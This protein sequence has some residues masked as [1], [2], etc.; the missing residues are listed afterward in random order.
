M[1]VLPFRRSSRRR[2]RPPSRARARRRRSARSGFVA[3][4]GLL[5]PWL[6]LFAGLFALFA[7]QTGWQW[8]APDRAAARLVSVTDGDTVRL[9]HPGYD[10]RRFRL[11]FIDAP[12]RDQ[13]F[14]TA[15]TRCLRDILAPGA[16]TAAVS[17]VDRY[18]RL[19]GNLY[20][21]GERVDVIMVE[22]GCA[23]WYRRYAPASFAL[24]RAQFDARRND[25]G[26][27]RDDDPVQPETW[28]HRRR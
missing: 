12:E 8:T 7:Q 18:G 13:A 22:R 21:D 2:R 20:V 5:A 17:K 3:A 15:A 28:R 26:L 10:E 24:A 23:W 1:R 25:R 19:V 6:V 27:W 14:G 11:A 9:H 4:L 16:I